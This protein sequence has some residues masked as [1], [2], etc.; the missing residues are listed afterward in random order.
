MIPWTATIPWP[1]TLPRPARFQPAPLPAPAPKRNIQMPDALRLSIDAF[2]DDAAC[3]DL[4]F[5]LRYGTGH[6]CPDCGRDGTWYP[7]SRRRA[8]SCQWCGHHLYPCAGTLFARSRTPLR[9]WF[10]AIHAYLHADRH[11]TAKA[12]ERELGVTY[13]TAWRMSHLVRRQL[14]SGDD[15][16]IRK[17]GR[18]MEKLAREV[19]RTN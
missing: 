18:R 15:C 12:L 19:T 8:Y 13:K 10:Y 14:A 9:L 5:G 2:P 4:V 3:L 17:I 11:V 7:L 1:E 6:T 16:L